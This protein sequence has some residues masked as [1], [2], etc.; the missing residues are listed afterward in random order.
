VVPYL[1]CSGSPVDNDMRIQPV[2]AP[3]QDTTH[4]L[5][6]A[7]LIREPAAPQAAPE[8]TEQGHW[9][10]GLVKEEEAPSRARRSWT[11]AW[12]LEPEVQDEPTQA[13]SW[14]AG[15]VKEDKGR[16]ALNDIARLLMGDSGVRRKPTP[17]PPP[18]RTSPATPDLNSRSGD[19]SKDAKTSAASVL[20]DPTPAPQDGAG[21]VARKSS[22]DTPPKETL[23]SR[24][25]SPDTNSREIPIAKPSSPSPRPR[26]NPTT[27]PSPSKPAPD[28]VRR[29]RIASR[30]KVTF[31]RALSAM[32]Q[33]GVPLFAIFEF[34]SRE[35]ES[36][37]LALACRRLGQGLVR[38]MALPV[39]ASLEPHLFDQ[40][41]V[42]L[43]DTGFRGGQLAEILAQL[44]EDEEHVW[45]LKQMLQSQLVYPC[46]IA[47]LTLAT[48][49]LLPPL[50]L[51]GLLEQVISMTSQPPLLTVLLLKFSAFLSSPW[52]LAVAGLALLACHLWLRSPRG[53]RM[54]QNLELSVWFLPALGP[55]WRNVVALRFLRVFAMTYRSGLAA[56]LGIELAAAATGSQL[57]FRVAPLMK[58][59][60][61]DGGSLAESFASGGFLPGVA[62]EA[63]HAGEVAGKVPT[64]CDSTAAILASEVESRID[65]VA[66]LIEPLVLAVLGAFVAVVV[67]GCL[68]PI[69]ELTSTL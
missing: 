10:A 22:P 68:L 33:A 50:V 12:D 67:L 37:E 65:A 60:L 46:G 47:L 25:S 2:P 15:L 48:V 26:K 54:L 55:L 39:A 56:T 17:L 42:R 49:V 6:A 13:T 45:K 27:A 64:M 66:K 1:N 14:L 31:Y 20:G 19:P 53:Q 18:G 40:K 8:Q 5:W 44:A 38:G 59:T 21:T 16:P 29:G 30:D 51:T 69:V 3:G 62:L 36:V 9:L 35:A 4:S 52:T 24:D 63:V 34:L 41:A 61:M 28:E 23:H 43:L 7:G 58:R 11:S 32:F 57:A